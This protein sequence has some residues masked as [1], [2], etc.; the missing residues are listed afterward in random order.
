VYAALASSLAQAQSA[1]PELAPAP[2]AAPAAAAAPV[3]A[4]TATNFEPGRVYPLET[5]SVDA[6]GLLT[7]LIA[8]QTLNFGEGR[9]PPALGLAAA[10]WYGVGAA[11]APAV[12]YAHGNRG[13]GFE[14]L[15]M[16][17][18]LPPLTAFVG[19]LVV[20][21]SQNDF[22]HDCVVQGY[23]VGAFVGV[24]ATAAFDAALAYQPP[25]A[26]T[27]PKEHWYGAPMLAIDVA[28]LALG[29]Y[30]Y[31]D[32]SARKTSLPLSLFAGAYTFG[33]IGAPIVHFANGHVAKGFL[34][35]GLRL[36][37]PPLI[38]P[39]AGLMGYCAATG[40]TR[41]CTQTGIGYGLLGGTLA[42]AL[43]DTFSLAYDSDEPKQTAYQPY[44]YGGPNFVGVGGYW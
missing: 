8:S 5:L 29:A 3:P 16:R 28:G 17:L 33:F 32:Q 15:S 19:F 12:H 22:N 14:S 25:K 40:G 37:A 21:S 43:F 36:G 24:L 42:V 41:G 11:G 34:S 20:C 18:L 10:I 38:G 1:P 44:V 39:L 27:K 23:S 6:A 4:A 7:G 30:G 13:V 35:L 26:R 31:T 2:A 9:Q